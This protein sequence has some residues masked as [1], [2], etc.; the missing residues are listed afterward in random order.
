M[1]TSGFFPA[2]WREAL[3]GRVDLL[4]W[5][6]KDSNEA[7]HV[8]WTGVGNAGILDNLCAM[9]RL[10]F[11]LRLR[12]IMVAGINTERAHY[13]AIARLCASLSHC[14]GVDLLPYHPYGGSKAEQLGRGNDG[15]PEWVPGKDI[16]DQAVSCLRSQGIDVSCEGR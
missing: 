4:L 8:C 2:E 12:C 11:P 14:E 3:V 1:E 7:R 15:R 5:D 10:G 13:D 6:F 16:L 9:D